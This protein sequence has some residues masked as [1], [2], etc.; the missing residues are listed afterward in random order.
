MYYI[1]KLVQSIYNIFGHIDNEEQLIIEKTYNELKD[2]II[3]K[4]RCK[5]DIGY[6]PFT[7]N[8][9]CRFCWGLNPE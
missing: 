3:Y 7:E 4:C 1:N 8:G 2:D 6:C 9:N 5:N